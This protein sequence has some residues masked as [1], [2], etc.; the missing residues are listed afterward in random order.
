MLESCALTARDASQVPLSADHRDR[1]ALVHVI[2]MSHRS[3][4]PTDSESKLS[5]TI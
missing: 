5:I 3:P 4:Y 2:L 1:L